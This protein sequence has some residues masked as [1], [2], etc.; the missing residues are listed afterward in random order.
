M[1]KAE[2]ADRLTGRTGLDKAVAREAVDGGF[3]AIGGAL[4]DGEE[5]RISGFGT[6]GTKSQEQTGPYRPQPEDGR[7][8][9]G[10]G[11]DIIDLQG[12]EDAEGCHQRGP[13]VMRLQQQTTPTRGASDRVNVESGRLLRRSPRL[14]SR[15]ARPALA[16]LC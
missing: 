10:I 6:F 14:R 1:N 9:F 13:R 16:R 4:A 12:R 15:T 8:S 5:V 3:A 11:V 2:M 7:G